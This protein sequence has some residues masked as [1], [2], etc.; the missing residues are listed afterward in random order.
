MQHTDK[1]HIPDVE[2]GPR[3]RHFR[4]FSSFNFTKIAK[5]FRQFYFVTGVGT[6][7]WAFC[8]RPSGLDQRPWRRRNFTHMLMRRT[9]PQVERRARMEEKNYGNFI[10]E[11]KWNAG[12]FTAHLHCTRIDASSWVFG[13]SIRFVNGR[14]DRRK[15]AFLPRQTI[16]WIQLTTARDYTTEVSLVVNPARTFKKKLGLKMNL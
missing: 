5:V 14:L 3:R 13:A 8:N 4:T 9:K 6:G 1:Y 11:S 2:D 15:I 10:R 12:I 7:I 16:R